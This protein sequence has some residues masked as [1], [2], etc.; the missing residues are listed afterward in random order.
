MSAAEKRS[1][2]LIRCVGFC[3]AVCMVLLDQACKFLAVRNLKGRSPVPIIP[4][5]LE[6]D[7]VENTGMAFGMMAGRQVF[8]I[9]VSVVFILVF[10]IILYKILSDRQKRPEALCL[11]VI[12]AGAAGNMLDRII[13]GYVVD[14]ISFVL[15]RFP[16]F[17]LADCFV[18]VGTIL[19]CAVILFYT[20]EY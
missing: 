15:I 6:L 11:T 3:A 14:Y 18:V 20:K 9:V 8:L 2:R 17:N 4:G 10:S 16:V 12:L 7:Y 13:R 19:F 5:V 1:R